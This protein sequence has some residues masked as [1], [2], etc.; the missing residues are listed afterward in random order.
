L[1][2]EKIKEK[3]MSKINEMPNSVMSLTANSEKMFFGKNGHGIARYDVA[4][5]PVFLKLNA[6]MQGFFWKPTE[7][8]MSQ[9]KRSFDSMTKSEKHLFTSNL[10]RQIEHLH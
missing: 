2:N 9:E 6:K 10:K 7:I 4:R 3:F 8:D 1:F 5:Y